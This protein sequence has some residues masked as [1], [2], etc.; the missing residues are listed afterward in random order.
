MEEN[1]VT[2]EQQKAALDSALKDCAA[3]KGALSPWEVGFTESIT[4][5]WLDRGTLT[6]KQIGVL[7]RIWQQRIKEPGLPTGVNRPEVKHEEA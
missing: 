2:E 1:T 6:D 7:R 5:Q 3:H 4:E